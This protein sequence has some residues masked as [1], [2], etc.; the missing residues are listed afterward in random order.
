MRKEAPQWVFPWRGVRQSP[1]P[2]IAAF[3]ITLGFFA[4][5]FVF[6]RIGIVTPTPWAPRQA[7]VF[8]ALDDAEGR[9]LALR[10]R[11]GGPFPSRFQPAE[12]DWLRGLEN[13]ALAAAG[14]QPPRH[15]PQLRELPAIEPPVPRLS[16]PGKP[17]LP[18]RPP[19]DPVPM[20]GK[21]RPMPVLYPLA[22]MDAADM[23][24]SLPE[25]VGEVPPAM[26]AEPWRFLLR[27]DAGGRVHEVVPLAGGGDEIGV[28]ALIDWL[29]GIDFPLDDRDDG[30]WIAVGLSFGNRPVNGTDAD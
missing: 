11:E 5:M 18:Q 30:R 10:A 13:Q 20:T 23:P 24:R 6:V 2:K 29:R 12:I 16:A 4:M 19:P 26:L 9:A 1:L 14:W 28:S 22:G 27:L 7:T 21:L 15:K 8:R 17:V 25:F 3:S